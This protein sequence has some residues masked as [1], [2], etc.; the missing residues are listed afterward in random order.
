[1][2]CLKKK[3]G[4]ETLVDKS[5]VIYC[6]TTICVVMMV[7][8]CARIK[9]MYHC[10]KAAYEAE[11][12]EVVGVDG[13]RWVDLQT[14][15]AFSSVFKQT[16]HGVQHFMG[17]QEEPLS[18][19]KKEME[20]HELHIFIYSLYTNILW[21]SLKLKLYFS[22]FITGPGHHNPDPPRLWRWRTIAS[23]SRKA[24]GP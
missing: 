17:Q 22:V 24:S 3:T 13:W 7:L 11:V 4:C 8:M 10:N 2:T 14:I 12:G 15:V 9:W 20:G 6:N 5:C 1:M 18:E 16:V 21:N 19:E 23:S